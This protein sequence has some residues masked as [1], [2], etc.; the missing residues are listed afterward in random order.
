MGC[1]YW[2]VNPKGGACVLLD[3]NARLVRLRPGY[4]AFVTAGGFQVPSIIACP[5]Q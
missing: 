3:Q 5:G 1:L 2:G 4:F